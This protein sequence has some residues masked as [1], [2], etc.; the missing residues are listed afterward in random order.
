[1]NKKKGDLMAFYEINFECFKEVL[2]E[3]KIKIE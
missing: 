2:K 3:G 1:M